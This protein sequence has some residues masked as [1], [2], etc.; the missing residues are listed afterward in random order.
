MNPRRRRLTD[1]PASERRGVDPDSRTGR[2][3]RAWGWPGVGLIGF[4]GAILVFTV[5]GVLA[6]QTHL[7]WVF[8]SLAPTVVL[9]FETPLRAQASPRNAVVGHVV[10]IGVGYSMLLFFGLSTAGPVTSTGVGPA[11]IG[12]A[13]LA[14]AVT[15]LV[16]NGAGL[17][18]PPAASSTLIVALGLL[19]TPRELA[20][21]VGA[22]V[23]TVLLC[24][25]LNRAGGVGVTLCGARRTS[26]VRRTGEAATPP[27]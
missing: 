3:E 12:A 21:M 8:P 19:H 10:G 26:S 25:G 13:G 23:L 1:L 7:P 18:H 16:I 24:W 27:E 9:M 4:A 6:W 15:T 5:L 20:V 2:L 17:P 22:A 14:V 11:R